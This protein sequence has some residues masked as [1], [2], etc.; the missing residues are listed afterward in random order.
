MEQMRKM[1][2]ED[3]IAESMKQLER[4]GKYSDEKLKQVKDDYRYGLTRQ[5]VEV[6]LKKNFSV[7]QMQMISKAL[8]I[9]GIELAEIIAKEDIDH[10][11]MQVAIEFYEKGVPLAAISESVIEKRNAHALRYLYQKILSDIKQTESDAALEK[12]TLD[13]SYVEQML[14]EMKKIVLQ[15]NH[16]DEK[17]EALSKKIHEIGT[18]KHSDEELDELY[19]RLEEKDL[20][21]NSQQ[22]NIQQ[23]NAAVARLRHEVDEKEKEMEKL[24]DT[25]ENLKTEMGQQTANDVAKSDTKVVDSK[26]E[27]EDTKSM[28]GA[29]KGQY[30]LVYGIPIQYAATVKDEK[31]NKPVLAMIERTEP[32]QFGL[33]T[34]I[35]KLAY[36]KKSRQDIVKLVASG[37]LKTEQLVQIRMAMQKGLTESQLLDLINNNVPADQMKEIIEIA[38]LENSLQ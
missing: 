30:P 23:A 16:N 34:L 17:Y 29:V 38:V 35:G 36:K 9:Q 33:H 20:L 7:K 1:M 11:C 28:I 24:K 12:E 13:V 32:K 27:V 2:D 25:I 19:K 18:V 14:E 5:E 3:A 8:R 15:I 37:D 6:Y 26:V 10:H 31:N 4:T 22:D 21:I